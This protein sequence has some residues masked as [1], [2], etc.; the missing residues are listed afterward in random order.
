M[1][2][3]GEEGECQ[4]F[5]LLPVSLDSCNFLNMF[6]SLET[7]KKRYRLILLILDCLGFTQLHDS[8]DQN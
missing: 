7:I 2:Y 4:G 1:N 6:I 3:R 8:Y 5:K